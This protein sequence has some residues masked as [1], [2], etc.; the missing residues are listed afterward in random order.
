[1]K[2]LTQ[3][4]KDISVEK[5]EQI[6][7]NIKAEMS[8]DYADE[9]CHPCGFCRANNTTQSTKE[10]SG[11]CAFCALCSAQGDMLICQTIGNSHASLAL[12]EASAEQFAQAL[13]HAEI[14]LH[15]IKDTPIG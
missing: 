15:A 13:V 4:L 1:M 5:W 8:D 2:N 7:V 9:H 6:I 11:A 10:W 14:V 12:K 3:A